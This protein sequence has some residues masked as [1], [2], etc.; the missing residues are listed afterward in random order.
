MKKIMTMA[1]ATAALATGASAQTLEERVEELE[2]SRDLNI[3]SFDGQLENRVDTYSSVDEKNSTSVENTN[4]TL[5]ATYFKLNM[6]AKPNDR[7]SFYGR[8]AMSK[9]WND[10]AAR[11][12]SSIATDSGS[13][14][15][16]RAGTKLYVE[17]AFINY[18][19]TNNLVYTIG[20]M[21]TVDGPPYHFSAGTARSGAYPMVSYAYMLDGMALT[22]GLKTGDVGTL[23]LRAIYTPTAFIDKTADWTD[24]DSYDSNGRKVKNT[25]N[26]WSV[27]ADYEGNPTDSYDGLNIIGQYLKADDIF[28]DGVLPVCSTTTGL[29]SG[30][31]QKVSSLRFKL[32]T[33]VLY[34]EMNGI[35]K[36]GLDLSLTWKKVKTTSTGT[37]ATAG[38][39]YT[40]ASTAASVTESSDNVLLLATAY[41]FGNKYKVGYEYID[42]GD[43][44]FQLDSTENAIGFYG[45]AGSKGSHAF[46]M[47][48]FNSSLKLVLGYMSKTHKKSYVNGVLGAGTNIKQKRTAGYA[49][50]IANF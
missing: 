46:A 3:F 30:T 37:Y 47:T 8:L 29:C 5:W 36:T 10:F 22:Y 21:P 44:A 32:D 34:A 39:M 50:L 16:D 9:S 42:I 6:S 11:G 43:K 15:R 20:R 35:A 27:M 24:N 7:L 49:R 12:G 31:T 2:L 1:F 40:P 25:S 45:G 41:N 23:N 18:S 48:K 28:L 19:I 13:G 14:G 26:M 4:K 17:R 33:I 38:G